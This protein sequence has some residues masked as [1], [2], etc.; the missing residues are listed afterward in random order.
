MISANHFTKDLSRNPAINGTVPAAFKPVL[1]MLHSNITGRIETP[2]EQTKVLRH[3][4]KEY[5]GFQTKGYRLF[6]PHKN[7]LGFRGKLFT[8][9]TLSL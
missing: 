5:H 1:M 8:E 4:C 3:D 6:F 9:K 2:R 7:S